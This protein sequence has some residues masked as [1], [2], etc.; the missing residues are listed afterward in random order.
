MRCSSAAKSSAPHSCGVPHKSSPIPASRRP[1]TVD[2]RQSEYS[3][4]PSFEEEARFICRA[5]G[6]SAATATV[7][8]DVE[9]IGKLTRAHLGHHGLHSDELHSLI[10]TDVNLRG[11]TPRAQSGLVRAVNKSVIR[12][13][14]VVN[15]II[16]KHPIGAHQKKGEERQT[17]D[18]VEKSRLE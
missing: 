1:S 8:A 9:S 3:L 11:H 7:C 16:S 15:I 14:I 17:S 6:Y 18:P 5:T 12:A 2:E 4:G 13:H 10:N